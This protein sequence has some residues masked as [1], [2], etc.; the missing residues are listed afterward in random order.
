MPMLCR[1]GTTSFVPCRLAGFE[2]D[3]GAVGPTTS[4]CRPLDVDGV[5]LE[6][7]RVIE[8]ARNIRE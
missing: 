7:L 4:T 6:G 3:G 1:Y 5:N 8:K 2:E